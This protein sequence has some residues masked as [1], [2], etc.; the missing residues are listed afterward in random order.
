MKKI[1]N[2][3]IIVF[4]KNSFKEILELI[5]F[6]IKL[7]WIVIIIWLVLFWFLYFKNWYKYHSLEATDIPEKIIL[8]LE[9]KPW[10]FSFNTKTW[11]IKKYL[12]ELKNQKEIIWK[13]KNY[14]QNK[15]NKEF[16]IEKDKIYSKKWILKGWYFFE[17]NWFWTKDWKYYIWLNR[18]NNHILFLNKNYYFNSVYII[19]LKT[20]REQYLFPWENK[21]LNIEEIIWYTN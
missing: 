3:K 6:F 4:I 13:Y 21:D 10:N 11:D 19:E 5:I 16:Y 8:K 17:T 18:Y 1:N 12:W 14:N 7:A 15:Y 9:N 20:W 2:D